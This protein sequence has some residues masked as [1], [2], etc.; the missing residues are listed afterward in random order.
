M[1]DKKNILVVEDEKDMASL[2]KM[3][4]TNL[5]YQVM[6]GSDGQQGLSLAQ[7]YNPALIVLDLMLPKLNG[8]KVCRMLKFD[9]KYKDIPIIIYSA[10][11][12][13]VDKQLADECGADAYISKT[14]GQ[15]VLVDKIKKLLGVREVNQSVESNSR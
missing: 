1:T 9:D 7:R 2:L 11:T 12:Q 8:H 15:E 14:L 5:G 6:I 10:R 4:L 3:R 13:E